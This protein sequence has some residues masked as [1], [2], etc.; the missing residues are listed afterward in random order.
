MR[1]HLIRAAS[2]TRSI[3]RKFDHWT[4]HHYNPQPPLRVSYW[5]T[6]DLDRR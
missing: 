1:R 4:L 2:V 6:G 5:R 3:G